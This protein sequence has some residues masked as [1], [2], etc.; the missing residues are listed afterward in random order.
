MLLVK[1]IL[2]HFASAKMIT[3]PSHNCAKELQLI[4]YK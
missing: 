2:L 1:N 3:T 4:V